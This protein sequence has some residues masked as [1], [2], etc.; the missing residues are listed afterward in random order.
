MRNILSSNNYD[1][2]SK[3]NGMASQSL[4]IFLFLQHHD[5]CISNICNKMRNILSSNNYDLTPKTNGMASQSLL[6]ILVSVASRCGPKYVHV[7][8]MSW[9]HTFA[10]HEL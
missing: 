4:L 3:T 7:I 2:T 9:R 10:T 6:N 8:R 1:L 5:V